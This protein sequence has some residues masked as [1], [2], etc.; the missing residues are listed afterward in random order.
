ML[1]SQY[2]APPDNL[3]PFFP[4]LGEECRKVWKNLIS[5]FI[6]KSRFRM[7]DVDKERHTWECYGALAE[8]ELP[9]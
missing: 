8:A 9:H 1:F 6:N 3:R 5:T 2:K 7:V 4:R